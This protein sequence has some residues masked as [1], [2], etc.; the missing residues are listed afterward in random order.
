[1]QYA[2]SRRS[3]QKHCEELVEVLWEASES[4]WL[5]DQGVSV[6]GHGLGEE[7]A[8]GGAGRPQEESSSETE[9]TD[10]QRTDQMSTR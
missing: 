1:M 7:T 5:E 4:V 9:T 6:C 10:K 2:D 8:A 3:P